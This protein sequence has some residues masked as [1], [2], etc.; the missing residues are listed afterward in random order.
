METLKVKLI[1]LTRDFVKQPRNVLTSNGTTLQFQI[2]LQL[3]LNNAAKLFKIRY[4]Y[5]T[6]YYK[7]TLWCGTIC[8]PLLR[9]W[10]WAGCK[11]PSL[12]QPP[13]IRARVLVEES[14]I[15]IKYGQF[16]KRKYI[17]KLFDSYGLASKQESTNDFIQHFIELM[18][19]DRIIRIIDFFM[20]FYFS[21]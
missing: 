15:N 2:S 3:L 9:M 4:F 18:Y 20:F 7:C 19:F 12:T 13:E 16:N 11:I 6:Q 10:Y 17:F 5:Y 1:L 8:L 21:F 14:S